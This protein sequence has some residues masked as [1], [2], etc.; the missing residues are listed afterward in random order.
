MIHEVSYPADATN[1]M[2]AVRELRKKSFHALFIADDAGRAG[3]VL[4]FL[5][6]VDIWTRGLK[7]ATTT[8]KKVR[9]VRL[10]GPASWHRSP[11]TLEARYSDG[12]TV[13]V[14]WLGAGASEVAALRSA[15]KKDLGREPGVFEALGWDVIR[16]VHAAGAGDRK[17]MAAALRRDEGFEGVLGRLRFS[18][19]GEPQRDVRVFRL[20]QGKFSAVKRGK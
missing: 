18:M 5:A 2:A 7:K 19:A 8:D 11:P 10:L 1:L 20:E 9:H 13:A 15:A 14:E 6:R 4:R 17:G 16:V 3:V 12:L